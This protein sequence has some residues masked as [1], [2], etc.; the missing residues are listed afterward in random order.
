MEAAI[1]PRFGDANAFTIADI[2]IPRPSAGQLL[3]KVKAAGLNPVDYKTRIGKGQAAQ[4][5]LPAILGWD[6]AGQIADAGQGAHRFKPGD[7]I[8][9]MSN[10][11]KPTNAYAQFAVV[12][13][14]EFALVPDNVTD[15]MAGAT[16][17]AALTA[18]E[19]L[20]DHARLKAGMRVLI[21]AAAGGVGH[22]A[23]QL[24]RLTDAFVIGTASAQNHAYVKELGANE[25]IDYR[26]QRFE[27][28]TDPVNVVIDL[29]GGETALRSLDIIEPGG[30]MVSLPS[31]YKDD[32]AVLAKAKEKKVQVIWMSVRPSGE[33][34]EQIAGL[35]AAEKLKVRVAAHFPL[36]EVGRAHQ[37]LESHHVQG[38]V[39]LIPN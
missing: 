30:I 10:F 13:E 25:C 31:M 12:Q 4:F 24:A 14:N 28:A 17:L 15:E 29:M 3:V 23:V 39:V 16:P 21:H 26:E 32:P 37:L 2:P 27:E 6:I 19:A 8:F 9:G 36:K 1:L 35:M 33:R 11:P 38:K 20:F 7:R 34:M 5:T 18:W 22:I